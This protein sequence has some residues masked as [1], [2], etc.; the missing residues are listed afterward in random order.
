LENANESQ[1]AAKPVPPPK[2]SWVRLVGKI[3]GKLQQRKTKKAAET[4]VDRAV[5]VTAT[6]T[7]WMAAFTAVLVAV[8]ILTL[9]VLRNQLKEM[10]EGGADTHDLAVAAKNQANLQHEQLEGT[11]GA[12]VTLEEPRLTPDPVTGKEVLVML[13]KNDGH[14]IAP[15]AHATFHIDTVS[16]PHASAVLKSQS[17]TVT[18]AQFKP[19][20]TDGKNY[21]LEDFDQRDRQFA[22]QTRTIVV[23]GSLEFEDGFGGLF[24]RPFCYS[25]I[26]IY[27]FK[28]EQTAGSTSGGGGF[29]P[30]DRFREMVAY[31][32]EHPWK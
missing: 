17:V 28:N 21:P 31:L 13:L 2:S 18:T 22:T 5:R 6:A 27:N 32:L 16:F 4:P 19:A 12:I 30:C 10:H 7:V 23:E 29:L 15:E 8:G 9:C 26:G 3:E 1:P 24:E 11:M 25:Y 20:A 14:V